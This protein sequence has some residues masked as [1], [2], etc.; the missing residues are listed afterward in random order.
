MTK[1]ALRAVASAAVVAAV[2]G[3]TSRAAATE[4]SAAVASQESLMAPDP[5]VRS[6]S[7]AA[8]D[9]RLKSPSIV[10]AGE[11]SPIIDP[12]RATVV[13]RV[14]NVVGVDAGLLQLAEARATDVFSQIGVRLT[15]V[16]IP[17]LVRQQTAAMCTLVL[18]NAHQNSGPYSDVQHALG[19][20]APQLHRAWIFWDR[21]DARSSRSTSVAIVLGDAIAHELGH[22]ML[23]TRAHSDAGIMQPSVELRFRSAETFTKSQARDILTRLEQTCAVTDSN[24]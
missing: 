20:A 7:P 24:H 18:V 15:W 3:G 14:N 16:E 10:E 19:Y 6:A 23:S 1:T 21:I 9:P 4:S 8:A 11:K 17:T 13:I 2:L 12:Q 5:R 22:L